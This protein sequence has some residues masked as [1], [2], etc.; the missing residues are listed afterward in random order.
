M[1]LFI[2]IVFGLLSSPFLFAE[3]PTNMQLLDSLTSKVPAEIKAEFPELTELSLDFNEHPNAWYVEQKIV[4]SGLFTVKEKDS[5]PKLS[6]LLSEFGVKYIRI[7]SD[8]LERQIHIKY[9][10][11]LYDNG[12]TKPHIGMDLIVKDRF[13][14]KDLAII[15]SSP[16]PFSRS[17]VPEQKTTWIDEALEPVI[18]VGSA[19]LTV[20]L[21]FTVRSN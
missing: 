6:I 12:I 17:P 18:L 2:Y 10:A 1:K 21:F 16:Y 7:S 4:N 8:S 15:E 20:I 19:A 13:S 11:V 14:E 9:E 5:I 3:L